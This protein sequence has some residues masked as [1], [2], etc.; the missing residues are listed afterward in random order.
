MNDRP[1]PTKQ[2]VLDHYSR[3]VPVLFNQ[4]DAFDLGEDGADDVMRPDNDGDSLF[5]SETWELMSGVYETRVLITAGTKPSVAVR[6]L[7]KI[8]EWIEKAPDGLVGRPSSQHSVVVPF[9]ARNP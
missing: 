4:Y 9:K 5:R 8:I 3:R 1:R 6:H 2:Q 7:R